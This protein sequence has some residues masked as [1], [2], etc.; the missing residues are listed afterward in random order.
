[1]SAKR[2]ATDVPLT[3]SK[4]RRKVLTQ[5]EKVEVI[6]AVNT[7]M[8]FVKAAAKFNCVRTQIANIM[9]NK[10]NTL[11]PIPMVPKLQ[12]NTFSHVIVRT[13]KSMK[14][15]GNSMLKLAPGTCPSTVR[16]LNLKL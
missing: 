11:V 14:K 13:L 1:M 9:N 5:C 10:K 16:C 15:C 8:N 2:K 4:S 12:P 6:E 7:G 3:P